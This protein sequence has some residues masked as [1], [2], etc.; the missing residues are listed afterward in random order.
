M[1]ER[2]YDL[3]LVQ[4]LS[5]KKIQSQ[6]WFK[7]RL[8]TRFLKSRKPGDLSK[9]L[10]GGQWTFVQ[11]GLDDFRDGLPPRVDGQSVYKGTKTLE[12]N[13]HGDSEGKFPERRAVNKGRFTKEELAFS[14]VTPLQQQRRDHIDEMEYGL[15]QHPL[16]L[17]PHLEESMPPDVFEDVVDI[18][19]PEMNLGSDIDEADEFREYMTDSYG[20]DQKVEDD[21][22]STKSSSG[23]S[24]GQKV[25]NPYRWLPRKEDQQKEDRRAKQKRQDSP[26]QDEHI[27]SITKEFCDWVS[28]L[29]GD[30]NNVEESTIHSLFASGYET[31]PAL[32]VPIHVVELTNVPAELRMSATV[33]Q[34]EAPSQTLEQVEKKQKALYGSGNYTPSWVKMNYGAWYLKPK[35]WERRPATE[36]LE[37]PQSLKD[38]EMSDSKKK[39]LA[40]DE[41]LAPLHGSHSFKEFIEKKGTRKPEFLERVAEFQAQAEAE[42]AAAKQLERGSKALSASSGSVRTSLAAK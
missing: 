24:Q 16:A 13:I 15:L 14:T 29:G 9:A 39:S 22:L 34:E 21:R 28:G 41:Q 26:S 38:K 3:L 36:P 8:R 1:A 7:E 40:M 17:Y 37:D 5:D 31:K 10:Q 6:E 19:D 2:K 20:G 18:L 4:T 35:T 25:R 32:S 12:P 27:K 33:S 11:D 30:S 23:S 42:A